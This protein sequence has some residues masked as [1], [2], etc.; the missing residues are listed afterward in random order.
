MSA[1]D[2]G[3]CDP[4]EHDPGEH[5]PG[6]YDPGYAL[7]ERATD[8]ALYGGRFDDHERSQAAWLGIDLDHERRSLELAVAVLAAADALAA[9]STRPPPDH[10][11]E[12][13]EL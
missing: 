5:D 11:T 13:L 9:A 12:G 2:H 4:G 3:E 1:Q 8:I 6:E 7:L 10:H